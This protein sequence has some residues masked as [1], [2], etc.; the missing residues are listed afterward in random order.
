MNKSRFS[1]S[2]VF[3]EIVCN[4]YDRHDEEFKAFVREIGDATDESLTAIEELFDA[5]R[6]TKTAIVKLAR[7]TWRRNVAAWKMRPMLADAIYR[8]RGTRKGGW[9]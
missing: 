6:E 9:N 1:G 7:S 8:R 5:L 3:V 2:D 4:M